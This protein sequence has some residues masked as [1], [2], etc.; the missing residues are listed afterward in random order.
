MNKGII[1]VVSVVAFALF[2]STG[3]FCDAPGEAK[4][5]A[6]GAPPVAASKPAPAADAAS[7]QA[8]GSPASMEKKSSDGSITVSS[9]PMVEEKKPE[10]EEKKPVVAEEKL[11]VDVK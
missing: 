3:A 6:V 10:V 8:V 11:A 4:K 9:Q 7:T 5:E 1:G 2:G